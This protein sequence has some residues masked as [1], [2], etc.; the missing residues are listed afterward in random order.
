MEAVLRDLPA[1]EEMEPFMRLESDERLFQ[2]LEKER[3]S[4]LSV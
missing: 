3:G 1:A 4:L 2:E